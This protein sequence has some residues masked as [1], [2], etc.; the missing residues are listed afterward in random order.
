MES[1]TRL[2]DFRKKFDAA[3]TE[4]MYYK[5]KVGINLCGSARFLVGFSLIV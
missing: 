2:K 5:R 3:M 1:A 4:Q